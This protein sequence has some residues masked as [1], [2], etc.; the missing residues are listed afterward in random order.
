MEHGHTAVWIDHHEAHVF[1]VEAESF[2]ESTIHAPEH[3]P[4]HPRRESV[5]HNHPDDEPRFFA[6]VAQSLRGADQVLILGPADAKLHFR[7]YVKTHA[8]TVGFGVAGVETV[9]HPT[10]NQIAA[11]VREYFLPADGGPATRH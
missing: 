7:E 2:A 6:E 3:S 8:A 10:D 1:R 5:L 4:R 11:L 9:D